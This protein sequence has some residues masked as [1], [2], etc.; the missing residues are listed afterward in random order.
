MCL[1]HKNDV[2]AKGIKLLWYKSSCFY[3]FPFKYFSHFTAFKQDFALPRGNI[4]KYYPTEIDSFMNLCVSKCTHSKHRT[5]RIVAVVIAG[6]VVEIEGT[7]VRIVVIATTFEERV[8][9]IRKVGVRYSLIP[10]ILYLS[11]SILLSITSIL[12]IFSR[13]SLYSS[14]EFMPN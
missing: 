10:N 14:T 13:I 8:A 1:W 12:I 5:E 9:R 6:I 2:Y 3:P 7:C 4:R 11:H